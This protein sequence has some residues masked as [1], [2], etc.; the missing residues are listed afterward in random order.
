M[1]IPSA[2]NRRL[3]DLFAHRFGGLLL[4]SAPPNW[5]ILL[6]R[7]DGPELLGLP[8]AFG[9]V[10]TSSDRQPALTANY[11]VFTSTRKTCWAT[12]SGAESDC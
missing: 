2:S 11:A 3:G 6:K 8:F 9:P 1:S 7:G 12:E 4:H 10:R 5:W